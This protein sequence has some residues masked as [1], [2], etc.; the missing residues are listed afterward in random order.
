MRLTETTELEPRASGNIFNNGRD[1]SLS[2]ETIH[3]RCGSVTRLDG[4]ITPL[5][6]ILS[7]PE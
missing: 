6:S 3:K 2:L 5:I 7:D 4:G 1:L